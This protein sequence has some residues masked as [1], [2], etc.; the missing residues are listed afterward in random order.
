MNRNLFLIVIL[1]CL[2]ALTIIVDA[3][4]DHDNNKHQ[5]CTKTKTKTSSNTVTVTVTSASCQPTL[6]TKSCEVGAGPKK[7]DDDCRRTTV[8][9]TPT[10]TVCV[11]A[12]TPTCVSPGGRCDVENPG[13]CCSQACATVAT[14]TKSQYTCLPTS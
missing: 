1:S 4:Y 6:A 8:T 11:I 13:E 5:H 7:R 14:A 12:V 2:L 3:T 9:C 10:K